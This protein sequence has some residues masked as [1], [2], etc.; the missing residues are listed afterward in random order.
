MKVVEEEKMMKM[1][2]QKDNDDESFWNTGKM[3]RRWKLGVNNEF[4]L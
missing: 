1:F 2:E 3:N 4:G